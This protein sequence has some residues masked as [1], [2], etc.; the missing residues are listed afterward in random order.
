[1]GDTGAPI[2]STQRMY[3]ANVVPANQA[4]R[5]KSFSSGCKPTRQTPGK[6]GHI[7]RDRQQGVLPARP[8]PTDQSPTIGPIPESLSAIGHVL[9]GLGPDDRISRLE[10]SPVIPLKYAP[11]RIPAHDRPVF[12]LSLPP[13]LLPAPPAKTTAAHCFFIFKALSCLFQ[14]NFFRHCPQSP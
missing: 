9:W 3:P 1:M 14:T 6:I 12:V 5:L 7:A 2:D 13:S 4:I 8:K 11:K 10:K